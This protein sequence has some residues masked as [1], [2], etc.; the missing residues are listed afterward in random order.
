M[1]IPYSPFSPPPAPSPPLMWLPLLCCMTCTQNESQKSYAQRA[2]S[3]TEIQL[4]RKTMP[5]PACQLSFGSGST[6]GPSRSPLAPLLWLPATR[7]PCWTRG[8]GWLDE[9]AVRQ[10]LFSQAS[11]WCF[12]LTFTLLSHAVFT[13][14]TLPSLIYINATHTFQIYGK[15]MFSLVNPK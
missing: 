14:L 1:S 5:R 13:Y 3:K 6:A 4:C 10:K 7:T 15:M 12:P 11:C 2:Q 9:W 8:G